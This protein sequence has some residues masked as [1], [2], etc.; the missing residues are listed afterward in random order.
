MLFKSE[1]LLLLLLLLLFVV[2]FVVPELL[3]VR[4]VNDNTVDDDDLF[5]D[6]LS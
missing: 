6:I 2:I 3:A 4:P 1:S 5:V